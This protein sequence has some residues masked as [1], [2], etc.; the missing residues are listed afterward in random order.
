[1]RI[2]SLVVVLYRKNLCFVVMTFVLSVCM[3]IQAVETLIGGLCCVGFMNLT[4]SFVI[5]TSSNYFV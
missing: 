4:G 2:V 5:E 1:V 3:E